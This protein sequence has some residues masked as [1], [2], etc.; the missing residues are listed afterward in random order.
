MPR[1]RW[2]ALVRGEDCPLC[3]AVAATVAEDEHGFTV[4]DLSMSRVRLAADQFVPGYCVAICR[5]HVREP[6]ELER[7]ER[8]QFFEDVM[9]LGLALERVFEAVKLNFELLGNSVPHLHC[10]VKP[11]FY[12]DSAPGMPIW[13]G[14]EPLRLQPGEYRARVEAIRIALLDGAGGH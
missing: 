9:Q 3:E 12:G 14:E 4:A 2:D 1:E 13:G 8:G 7:D 10:H 6:Y 5:R 11:R